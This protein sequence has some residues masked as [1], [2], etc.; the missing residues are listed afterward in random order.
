[1]LVATPFL[2][3]MAD[4]GIVSLTISVSVALLPTTDPVDVES[5]TPLFPIPTTARIYCVI[6]APPADSRGNFANLMVNPLLESARA[7]PPVTRGRPSPKM[8][9]QPPVTRGR[10]SP[11][12]REPSLRQ[13]AQPPVTRGIPSLSVRETSLQ[14][15]INLH[16]SPSPPS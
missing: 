3:S 8:R 14:Q 9:D 11:K 5:S 2:H 7:Q 12:M 6:L 13:G 16:Q 15:S 4:A 1:M 10:P